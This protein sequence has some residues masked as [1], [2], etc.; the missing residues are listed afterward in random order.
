MKAWFATWDSP[1]NVA[2]RD[3]KVFVSGDVAFAHA[4]A[5]MGG[6]KT[7][8]G[9]IGLWYRETLGYRRTSDGWKVSHQHQSTPFYMDG[10]LKAAVDLKP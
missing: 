6:D 1:I 3:L 2:Y 10:S 5:T 7:G 9:E 4:L 8:E